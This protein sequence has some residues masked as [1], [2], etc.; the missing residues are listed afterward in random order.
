MLTIG[1]S[2]EGGAAVF[3]IIYTMKELSFGKLM[4]VYEQSNCG[5]YPNLPVHQALIQ[6]EQ[7]QY[8]YLRNV[9]FQIPCA[10]I[11]V[12]QEAGRYVSA[13]RVEPYR[14]GMLLTALETMPECRNRGYAV[15]LLTEVQLW[16]EQQGDVVLYS[17]IDHENAASIAVHKKCGFVKISD[18]AAYLDGSVSCRAGTYRYIR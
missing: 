16:Q 3:R 8:D 11:C 14:D 4:D 7:E 17:H 15:K 13:V 10:V 1:Y 6:A 2:D 18:T 12:L 9:F 5:R